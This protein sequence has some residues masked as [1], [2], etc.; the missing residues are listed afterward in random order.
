M[1]ASTNTLSG[2]YAAMA[3]II[4]TNPANN[5]YF[6]PGTGRANVPKV[7]VV[8]TDGISN[9]PC[10]CK[11]IYTEYDRRG[12][13]VAS[14]ETR[15]D[16]G[17]PYNYPMTCSGMYGGASTNYEPKC[18]SSRYPGLTCNDCA[19]NQVSCFPC[20]E[21]I[22]LTDM[23]N[24]WNTTATGTTPPTSMVPASKNF[25]D[26]KVV[27]L[28]I[29]DALNNNFGRSQISGMHYDHDPSKILMVGWQNLQTVVSSVVDNTCN[30]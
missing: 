22:K 23:I 16:W 21:P 10:S 25:K 2:I 8:V 26:W 12:R 4:G 7:L 15:F 3:D 14:Y 11:Y 9:G 1:A 18:Q 13:P 20:A 5:S 28:G 24:S 17:M 29:G 19:S 30:T 27:A 6:G